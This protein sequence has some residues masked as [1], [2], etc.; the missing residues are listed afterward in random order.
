VKGVIKHSEQMK[1]AGGFAELF[2]STS[3]HSEHTA[4][5]I[6]CNKR[7]KM[8]VTGDTL[9]AES[10]KLS[11]PALVEE[12]LLEGIYKVP[13]QLAQVNFNDSEQ[14]T[15]ENRVLR[16]KLLF[17][18]IGETSTTINDL[19]KITDHLPKFGR[20]HTAL[21]VGSKI[22]DWNNSSVC[23]PRG[24]ESAKAI[25]AIDIA[26]LEGKN[27]DIA[28]K[29]L[30][31]VIV[32]WNTEG[33]Y[34]LLNANCQMFVDDC[35]QMMGIDFQFNGLFGEYIAQVRK[36]G[37]C[38]SCLKLSKELQDEFGA[39]FMQYLGF[40]EHSITFERHYDLDFFTWEVLSRFH[41]KEKNCMPC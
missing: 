31:H 22:V 11:T 25:L 18:D 19:L 10:Y 40:N 33:E 14:S 15:N 27:I 38:K 21:A 26:T 13:E 41:H 2:A 34:G 39:E 16:I 3:E 35:L 1:S 12:R 7:A 5:V 6:V 29:A 17:V 20:I 8:G 30:S 36:T 23:M 32:K 37:K 24:C 9:S 4:D 28:I